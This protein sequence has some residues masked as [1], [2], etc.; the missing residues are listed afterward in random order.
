MSWSVN[1]TAK[2]DDA[3][4]QLHSTYRY[5]PILIRSVIE[6]AIDGIRNDDAIILIEGFGHQ[7]TKDSHQVTDVTLKVRPIEITS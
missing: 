1:I 2:K 3:K 6:D 4:K 7:A 5:L